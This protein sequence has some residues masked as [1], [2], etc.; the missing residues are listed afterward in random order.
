MIEINNISK[1]YGK[2]HVLKNVTFNIEKGSICGFIGSNGA[3]KTTT[4]NIIAGCTVPESGEVLI[5]GIKAAEAER[6]INRLIGY[7]PEQPPLYNA[8]TVYEYLDCICAIKGIKKNRRIQIEE[9]AEYTGLSEMLGRR[10]KNLSKGYKQRVGIAYALLGTPEYIILDEPTSGLD[11][12]QK[13]DMLK[14]I[15]VLGREHGILLSSHILS[16]VK[17]V[18]NR[19]IMIDNGKIVN[20]IDNGEKQER[21]AKPFLYCVKGSVSRVMKLG[22][23]CV[24]I[25]EFKHIDGENYIAYMTDDGIRNFFFKAAEQKLL[26]YRQQ[27]YTVDIEKLF[28]DSMGGKNGSNI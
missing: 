11:P 5:N 20:Q 2:K 10:C 4:M 9:T 18:C 22:R 14:L 25:N 1:S 7:L 12:K 21:E 26:I 17:S 3:G 16:E 19:I 23:S 24:G 13:R 8:F 6:D 28:I 15:R 27:P